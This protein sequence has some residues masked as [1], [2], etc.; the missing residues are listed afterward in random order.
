MIIANFVISDTFFAC[1]NEGCRRSDNHNHND[2]DQN[3]DNDNLQPKN[4]KRQPKWLTEPLVNDK[5]PMT[6]YSCV[7]SV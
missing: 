3:Y 4:D 5:R 2:D 1:F 7:F 6:I